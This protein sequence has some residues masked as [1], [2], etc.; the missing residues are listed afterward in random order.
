MILQ[1]LQVGWLLAMQL[2]SRVKPDVWTKSHATRQAS[3]Y[4]LIFNDWVGTILNGSLLIRMAHCELK[5]N[6]ALRMRHI[7]GMKTT[8]RLVVPVLQLP[9]TF[10]DRIGSYGLLSIVSMKASRKLDSYPLDRHWNPQ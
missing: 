8:D 4:C 5:F 2:N 7:K 9:F 6:Y 10:L 1:Q 3:K